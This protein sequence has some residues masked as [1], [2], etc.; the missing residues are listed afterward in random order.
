MERRN[1]SVP[2]IHISKDKEGERLGFDTPIRKMYVA[3]FPPYEG[4]RKKN[5]TVRCDWTQR[6]IL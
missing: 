3:V 1:I 2:V 6:W 4:R 5:D